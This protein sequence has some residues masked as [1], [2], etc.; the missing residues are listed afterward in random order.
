MSVEEKLAKLIE[1]YTINGLVKKTGYTYSYIHQAAAGQVKIGKNLAKRIN[2]LW[3][4]LQNKPKIIRRVIVFSTD[5]E[6][7]ARY[8]DKLTMEQR[9][10]MVRYHLYMD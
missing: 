2:K 1:K 3:D 5:D 8:M 9:V 4:Q 7:L 6:Y 10:R